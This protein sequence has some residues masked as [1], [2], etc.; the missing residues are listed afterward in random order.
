M[1]WSHHMPTQTE[2]KETLRDLSSTLA[3]I[4]KGLMDHQMQERETRTG[5]SLN[6]ATKLNL[7]LQ[8]PEFAWL[9]VL[10]QLMVL[11]DDAFFQ[12]EPLTE[13]QIGILKSE[14][15]ELLV[16]Q[17][18]VDF[19]RNFNAIRM[20]LPDVIREHEKLKLIVTNQTPKSELN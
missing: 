9:R 18:N 15:N 10:S 11:V 6:P 16:L 19:A 2:L 5:Q 14:A 17:T 8:D 20:M 1:G 13:N 4:H 3:R 12:K 7:L